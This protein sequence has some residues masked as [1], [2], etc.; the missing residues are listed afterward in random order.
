MFSNIKHDEICH[1]FQQTYAVKMEHPF[2][3]NSTLNLCVLFIL[4]AIVTIIAEYVCHLHLIEKL[5]GKQAL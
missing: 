2:G 1:V 5:E 4:I 3:K